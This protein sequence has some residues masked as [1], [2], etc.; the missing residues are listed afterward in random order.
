MDESNKIAELLHEVAETH[1][2]VY[3]ITDGDD[4]D[5]ASW[6]ADW[7]L[8][9]SELPKL[10]GSTPVR[11]HLV[12]ELVQSDRDFLAEAPQEPWE[13]YYARRLVSMWSSR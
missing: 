4:P 8:K 7:L 6:Y 2:V 13:S 5:W 12:H 1:H 11:S 3:R 9:L 10:L